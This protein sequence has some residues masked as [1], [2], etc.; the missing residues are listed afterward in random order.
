MDSPHCH[1]GHTASFGYCPTLYYRPV[2][3]ESMAEPASDPDGDVRKEKQ[4]NDNNK[5]GCQIN[6]DEKTSTETPPSHTGTTCSDSEDTSAVSSRSLSERE[7]SE[8][9]L[10]VSSV[11]DETPSLSTLSG[12]MF[13]SIDEPQTSVRSVLDDE[14]KA[15]VDKVEAELD[16]ALSWS[17]DLMNEEAGQAAV[18][19]PP[20]V[21]PSVPTSAPPSVQEHYYV[22]WIT[23]KGEKTPIIT[24]SEN[25]PCPLLAIMNIL[26]LRWKVRHNESHT[27]LL[28]LVI[29]L[30][31]V[32]LR[33]NWLSHV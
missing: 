18:S 32:I 3:T 9:T 11:L 26:F 2:S 33:S 13:A 22:K 29:K 14:E 8:I 27:R 12:A 17:K 20:S 6:E 7:D 5:A 31:V 25:G 23:W 19:T 24:Q 10:S 16:G 1:T 4:T 30:T 28:K 15:E 21:P